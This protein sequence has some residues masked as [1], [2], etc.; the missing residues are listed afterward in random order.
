MR[1]SGKV[2]RYCRASRIGPFGAISGSSVIGRA[3]SGYACQ[4]SE[5]S[6]GV[7]WEP[8]AS[9]NSAFESFIMRGPMNQLTSSRTSGEGSIA[10]L[11][12]A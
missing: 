12:S 1:P 8:S 6:D 2:A 10:R 3:A 5:T 7:A 11:A 9:P 4:V